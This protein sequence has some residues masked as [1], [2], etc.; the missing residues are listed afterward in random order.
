M[1]SFAYPEAIWVILLPLVAYAI[2]PVASKMYGDALRVPFL[3]DILKIKENVRMRNRFRLQ[4]RSISWFKML[5]LMFVWM[6]MT[7]ALC[8][9]QWAGEPQRVK[10]EGRDIL[11]VVDI[12]NSMSER[13]FLYRNNYYSRIDAVKS[14]VSHFADERTDD[15]IGLVLFGTRAYMQVPLTYDKKSLKEVLQTA[16]AGMAGN[17]TSIGDA[18]AVAL[19]NLAEVDNGKDNKIIILL[20]DGE[21]NDGRMSFPQAIKLAQQEKVKVYTI[22][23]GSDTQPFFGG[24]F[25]IPANSGLDERSLQQLA[26][27]TEGTYFRAKDVDSLIKIYDEINKMEAQEQQGRFVQE[28]KDLFYYPAAVAGMLFLCLLL[29]IRKVK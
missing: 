27:A 1:I 6:F 10:H 4:N 3:K 8:R 16:T 25:A 29:L 9:P 17:S 22:G 23:A 11:L 26:Q 21:N 12:S 2:L 20:T 5:L 13:D 14:V 19:K 15:R 28:V 7:V 24:L 18:V